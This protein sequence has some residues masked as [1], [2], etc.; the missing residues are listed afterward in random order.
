LNLN[1]PLSN[2]N[3]KINYT[4]NINLQSNIL[5]KDKNKKINY[6]SNINLQSNILKKVNYSVHDVT[7]LR[8][9]INF[10]NKL[11]IP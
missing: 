6:T 11:K 2:K 4:S 7:F 8:K 9:I 10:L 1:G 5:K 3:K